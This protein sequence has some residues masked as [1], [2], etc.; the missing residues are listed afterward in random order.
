MQKVTHK[1]SLEVP[2]NVTH[3]YELDKRN[4]N[5]IWEYTIKKEMKYVRVEFDVK[6]KDKKRPLG[7][8]YLDLHLI[9]DVN[10]DFSW[11]ARFVVN[12]STNPILSASTYVG[13]V[14][15]EMVR[16]SFTYAALNGLDITTTEI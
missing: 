13:V 7:H 16:V 6:G 4:N 3:T 2:R 8:I 11:K 5:M 9:F 12:S 1:Y 14:S 15:R 10:M